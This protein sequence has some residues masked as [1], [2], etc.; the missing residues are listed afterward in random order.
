[1]NLPEPVPPKPGQQSV[2]DYPR[3]PRVV[4]RRHQCE[5]IYGG[6]TIAIT[7]AP[8]IVQERSHPPVYYFPPG[9]VLAGALEPSDRTSWCEW[10]GRASYFNVVRGNNRAE[11]AAWT[12]RQ[13]LPGYEALT[14]HVAFYVG[15]M[16]VCLV[17]GE[18]VRPQPGGFYGGWVTSKVAGPFKGVAGSAGW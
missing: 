3:P 2:W 6:H 4:T 16:E 12:Y 14:D 17:D 18:M 11:D 10:K 8:Q 7:L 15:L 1:M 9:S 13:P 5:V